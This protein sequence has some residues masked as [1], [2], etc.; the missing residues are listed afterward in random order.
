MADNV[1]RLRRQDIGCVRIRLRP[2]DHL[3]R[4]YVV[5]LVIL[6][7]ILGVLLAASLA[8]LAATPL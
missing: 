4:A 2:I 1:G 3:A 8:N 5:I 7:V 6:P